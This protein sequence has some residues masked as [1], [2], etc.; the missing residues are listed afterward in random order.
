MPREIIAAAIQMDATPAPTRDRLGR[1]ESLIGQAAGQGAHLVVLPELFNTGYI[2]NDE[3]YTRAE[4]EH[5]PTPTWM[6][7]T[8]RQYDVYLAG[9]L[10]L[11]DNDEVFNALLLYA[12]D[13]RVWRYDKNFPWGWERAYYREGRGITI[14]DTDLG[15]LGLMICWD[16]T[17]S[18]LWR[19]YAG[20]VDAMVI[21]SCPPKVAELDIVFPNDDRERVADQDAYYSG[22]DQ[23]FGAD[24]DAHAAWMR[25]PLINTT[26]SGTLRTA[27]PRTV[28]SALP[29]VVTRPRLWSRL[30]EIRKV[31]VEAGYYPQT[32]IVGADG[33]VLARV[34]ADGDAYTLSSLQLE[35]ITP[36]PALAQPNMPYTT[37]AYFISDLLLPLLTAPLYRRG[38]R[39]VHGK[40]MAP[41]DRGTRIWRW[42]A[43]GALALG[44]LLGR[45]T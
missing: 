33:R 14:A 40:E 41:L 13:G 44:F 42:V 21:A 6:T 11:K 31:E 37:W 12:P 24:L 10:L 34:E 1:A 8:A 19:R 32:K 4:D 26:G 7:Q 5:G 23:P 18:D 27:V 43:F 30:P 20:K 22:G 39:A 38:Y 35:D 25:V 29:T 2:Y 16:Y 3:N 17:H 45:I 15:K 9:S 36:Q 28:L